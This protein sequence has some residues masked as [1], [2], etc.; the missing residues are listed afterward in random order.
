MVRIWAKQGITTAS[1]KAVTSLANGDKAP[2]FLLTIYGKMIRPADHPKQS[3][4][5]PLLC[6]AGEA[7]EQRLR[8]LR[9]YMELLALGAALG[10]GDSDSGCHRVRA[11]SVGQLEEARR[12]LPLAAAGLFHLGP[13]ESRPWSVPLPARLKLLRKNHHWPTVARER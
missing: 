9:G 1:A 13:C 3:G 6:S 8:A 12:L 7:E 2:A 11:H 4:A 10:P 5:E